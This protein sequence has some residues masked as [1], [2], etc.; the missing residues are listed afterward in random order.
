M[1]VPEAAFRDRLASLDREPF[2]EESRLVGIAE[3]NGTT[4]ARVAR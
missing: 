1:T 2:A 4:D 3:R